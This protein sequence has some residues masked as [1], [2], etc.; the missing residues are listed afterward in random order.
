MI[1][2]S[3]AELIASVRHALAHSIQPALQASKREG[4][5][6][7]ACLVALAYAEA[8]VRE[9]GTLLSQDSDDMRQLLRSLGVELPAVP[10]GADARAEN[11]TLREEVAALSRRPGLPAPDR[12]QVRAMVMRQSDRDFSLLQPLEALPPI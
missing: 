4:G 3:P 10:P 6:I 7:R 2:I 1:D 9:E 12:E 11:R 8:L 5:T